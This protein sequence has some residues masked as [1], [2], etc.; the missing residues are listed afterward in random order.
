[1]DD[2]KRRALIRSKAAKKKETGD[3][4]PTGT[5]PSIPSVKRKRYLKGT[6]LP[7]RPKSP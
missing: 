4:A 2:A 7:K 1:M 5:G 3:V 6:V